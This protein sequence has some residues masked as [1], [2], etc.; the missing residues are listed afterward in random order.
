[1]VSTK[2]PRLETSIALTQRHPNMQQ[3]TPIH[4]ENAHNRNIPHQIRYAQGVFSSR[5]KWQPV[6]RVCLCALEDSLP[7]PR[8]RVAHST[9]LERDI[10]LALGV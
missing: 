7:F 3:M 5:G 8:S 1:M 9:A 10:P 6:R 2:S 4:A